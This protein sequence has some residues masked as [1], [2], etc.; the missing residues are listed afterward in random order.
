VVEK[1]FHGMHI[2]IF[3]CVCMYELM[4][5]Q[6]CSSIRYVYVCMS[7]YM[8]VCHGHGHG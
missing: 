5:I 4:C 2:C 7:M 6:G 1:H 8:Y 3:M